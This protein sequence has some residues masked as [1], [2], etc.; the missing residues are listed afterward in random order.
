MADKICGNE[1]KVN[2]WCIANADGICRVKDC[3]GEIRQLKTG[4]TSP[5]KAAQMYD[6]MKKSFEDYF[7]EDYKDM[8]TEE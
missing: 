8:D 1:R 5:D 3:I 2:C 4:R 7:S 6:V